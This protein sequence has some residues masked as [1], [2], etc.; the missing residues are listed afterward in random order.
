[1]KQSTAQMNKQTLIDDYKQTIERLQKEC[2]EK[3]DFNIKLMECVKKLE[4]KLNAQFAEME[5]KLTA[6]ELKNYELKEK[7]KIAENLIYE[8]SELYKNLKEKEQECEELKKQLET[9]E[10]WRIKAENLNEKLVLKNDPYRKALEEIEDF[11]KKH[12]DFLCEGNRILD[13]INKIKG[14]NNG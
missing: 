12:C 2:T 11:R 9:S 13:I 10:K 5:E 14:E 1:M 8:N 7:L 3:T 6:E 4:Q